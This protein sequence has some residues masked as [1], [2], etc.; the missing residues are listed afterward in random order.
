M[1]KA[2]L[3]HE[4]QELREQLQTCSAQAYELTL[5]E[6]AEHLETACDEL[7]EACEVSTA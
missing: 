4:I 2:E 6:V 1:P 7:E 3:I 5:A